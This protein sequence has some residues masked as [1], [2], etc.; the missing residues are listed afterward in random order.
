MT[1]RRALAGVAPDVPS[2]I[3]CP[4]CE[5]AFAYSPA[6]LGKTVQCRQCAHR[7]E[8]TGPP[9]DEPATIPAEP[10]DAAP[11][12]VTPPPLPAA[13]SRT[14]RPRRSPGGRGP[15]SSRTP[16]RIRNARGGGP[17][18]GS[19]R[20][21]RGPW[22]AW[23]PC[24]CSGSWYCERHHIPCSGRARPSPP[25][26]RRGARPRPS[27]SRWRRSPRSGSRTSSARPRGADGDPGPHSGPPTSPAQGCRPCSGRG[28]PP[29]SPGVGGLH[30]RRPA[31]AR[32]PPP[33][34][35]WPS[36]RPRSPATGP[37]SCSAGRSIRR[38]SPAAAGSCWSTSRG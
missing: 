34:S 11:R 25:P 29:R 2:R 3:H 8:V 31:T 16:S 1:A 13:S 26:R 30:P 19:V 35:R 18:G 21:A 23:P 32:N 22:S 6:L 7:F 24:A 28:P 20:A 9:A 4:E 17:S 12:S 15:G 27:R 37:R 5:T 10:P 33:P 14:A 36:S 38:P